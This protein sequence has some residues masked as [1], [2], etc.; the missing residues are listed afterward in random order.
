MYIYTLKGVLVFSHWFNLP[1]KQNQHLIDDPAAGLLPA[2]HSL[3]TKS[4]MS[5]LSIS[6]KVYVAKCRPQDGVSAFTTLL[7]GRL[8]YPTLKV[9]S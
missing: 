1:Q 9:C 6:S 5:F 3:V 8:A 2:A 7:W 4:V